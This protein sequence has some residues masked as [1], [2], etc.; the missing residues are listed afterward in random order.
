MGPARGDTEA[1]GEP[2]HAKLLSILDKADYDV[3]I[4]EGVGNS[5]CG[6]IFDSRGYRD[7]GMSQS[8]QVGYSQ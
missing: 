1:Q 5:C 7:V 3:I 2:V 6:M 8:Q 4:P